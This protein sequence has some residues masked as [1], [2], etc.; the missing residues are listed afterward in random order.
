MEFSRVEFQVW[1]VQRSIYRPRMD[2]TEYTI[3]ISRP[4]IA[5]MTGVFTTSLCEADSDLAV[6]QSYLL[7]FLLK[8]I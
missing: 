7:A 3:F 4:E 8:L 6:P 1:D 2:A 5:K